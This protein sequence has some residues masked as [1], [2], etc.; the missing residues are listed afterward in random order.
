MTAFKLEQWMKDCYSSNML[1]K[2]NHTKQH[3]DTRL[4]YGNAVEEFF[5]F[6]FLTFF[7]LFRFLNFFCIVICT[8]F[9]FALVFNTSLLI[10]LLL[11]DFCLFIAI[12]LN[13]LN[14]LLKFREFVGK[15]KFS[16]IRTIVYRICCHLCYSDVNYF[17]KALMLTFL[18]WTFNLLLRGYGFTRW[19]FTANT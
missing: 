6:L 2:L 8:F 1:L 12:Y 13:S 11:F 17:I 9:N 18:C 16:L 15:E 5:H 4:L 19:A 14:N 7:S 3:F 10:I